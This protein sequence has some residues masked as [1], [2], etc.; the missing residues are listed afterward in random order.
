MSKDPKGSPSIH[1][2]CEHLRK[3][4]WT[5]LKNC[6]ASRRANQW[7]IQDKKL[8]IEYPGW[9][10]FQPVEN[11]LHD[12]S[13]TPAF[14][15]KLPIVVETNASEFVISTILLQVEDGYLKLVAYN[16]WK[17]DKIEI[18]YEIYDKEMLTIISP[19]KE[20]CR[21]LWGTR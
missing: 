15:P 21:Y 19:F 17:M 8:L 3:I 7:G 13:D 20:L 4:Y 1:G 10:S 18:N 9:S 14:W 6:E 5:F 11:K 16:S 2:I 12:S